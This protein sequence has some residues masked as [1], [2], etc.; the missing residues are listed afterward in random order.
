MA[1]LEASNDLYNV[2]GVNKTATA[3]QIKK[4]YYKAALTCHPD[5][6]PDDP[7]ATAKFQALSRA[8]AVLS[9]EEKRAVYDATGIVDDGTDDF[10][11]GEGAGE[12]HWEEYFRSMFPAVTI[13]KVEKFAQSYRGSEEE[14]GHVLDAYRE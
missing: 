2:I 11:P 7:T 3:S 5:K 4:A 10:G 1:S 8:H 14:R 6:F 12:D 13:E 9:D